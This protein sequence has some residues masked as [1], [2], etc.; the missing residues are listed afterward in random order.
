MRCDFK[1]Q[2]QGKVIFF[3][4]PLGPIHPKRNE[5]EKNIFVYQKLKRAKME[6]WFSF[7]IPFGPIQG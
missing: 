3:P 6:Y 4:I 2:I 7:Y 1:R 5:Y